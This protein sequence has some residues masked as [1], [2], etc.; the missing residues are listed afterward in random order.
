LGEVGHVKN[1][2]KS[3]FL[4]KA[5]LWCLERAIRGRWIALVLAVA[6]VYSEMPISLSHSISK[7]I[8]KCLA[9]RLSVELNNLVSRAQSA[10]I[11]SRSIQ[12]NFL[13]TQ[14]LLRALH[15]AKQP[16]LF[17]KLDIAKAF[18]S[19]RWDFLLEVLHCFGFG[20]RWRNWISILLSTSSTSVLLNGA[21]GKWFNH[22]RGLRQGDPLS[23]MLF[24]LAMEPLQR[25][26]EIA[27][28][29]WFGDTAPC[30]G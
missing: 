16:G 8:S 24:I 14:N 12:D 19:I 27:A 9:S 13:Y 15:R 6:T 18:D 2:T 22:F 28:R 25:L 29:G 30:L 10:F 1:V 23:S 3:F 11:K 26:M 4:T 5:A 7:L 21:R 17:L 20:A